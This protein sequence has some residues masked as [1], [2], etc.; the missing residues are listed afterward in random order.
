MTVT[1]TMRTSG[2]QRITLSRGRGERDSYY[3]SGIPRASSAHTNSKNALAWLPA[4]LCGSLVLVGCGFEPGGGASYRATVVPRFDTGASAVDLSGDGG[5]AAGTEAAA[6]GFGTIQARV[7]FQGNAPSLAPLFAKGAVTKDTAV[8]GAAAIPNETFIASADGGVANVFVYLKKAPRGAPKSSPPEE[9]VVFDQ[10]GCRF[11]P[12]AIIAH[13][14]QTVLI[15]SGD[16][17]L[18]NTHTYPGRNNALNT[19]IK[20]NDRVGVPLVYSRRENE[21]F[22]VVCDIHAW[23][24]AWHLPLDH[25]YAGVTDGNGQVTIDN[26]PAGK[27]SFTIWHEQA[28]GGYV[29][30]RFDITVTADSVTEIEIPY[31]A[32]S[33]ALP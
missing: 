29:H 9:P 30:R 11:I 20:P 8:C 13:T 3:A 6:E 5:D 28:A 16:A 1:S 33:L 23:M 32:E 2:L 21:P 31:P 17:L 14:G 24:S 10:K 7:V 26:V 19:A 12:H 15:K 4:A 22:R 25:P 18:H 27:H